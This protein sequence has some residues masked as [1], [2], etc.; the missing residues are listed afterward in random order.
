MGFSSSDKDNYEQ[1]YPKDDFNPAMGDHLLR[2]KDS[3]GP[4]ENIFVWRM[5]VT[6][7]DVKKIW[8]TKYH[9]DN[10]DHENLF[11]AIDF[12]K[13]LITLCNDCES[14]AFGQKVEK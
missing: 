1:E 7:K 14:Y 8:P 6:S 12:K 4:E 9:D 2:L 5:I 3:N 11:W 13:R 10:C